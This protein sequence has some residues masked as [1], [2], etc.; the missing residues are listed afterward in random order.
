LSLIEPFIFIS[1][2]ISIF[3][4]VAPSLIRFL[5]S[6][7][8]PRQ[9]IMSNLKAPLLFFHPRG[10][11]EEKK[12]K[13][14][15]TSTVFIIIKR[16]LPNKPFHS[17]YFPSLVRKSVNSASWKKSFPQNSKF[18]LPKRLASGVRDLLSFRV[19]TRLHQQLSEDVEVL[20]AVSDDCLRVLVLPLPNAGQRKLMQQLT[21]FG[22]YPKTL[23]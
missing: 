12:E 7:V 19:S 13:K 11:Y 8:F 5:G 18:S 17:L 15:V 20:R 10:N 1:F 21:T 22:F 9:L 6:S 2:A 3:I 16:L 23:N 4:I 14:V